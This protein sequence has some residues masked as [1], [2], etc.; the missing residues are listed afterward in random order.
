MSL[1]EVAYAIEDGFSLIMSYNVG[2][3]FICDIIKP[4]YMYERSLCS[5]ALS[6]IGHFLKQYACC[7]SGTMPRIITWF[8]LIALLCLVDQMADIL[9]RQTS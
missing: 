6:H 4:L 2:Y 5:A 9:Q 1:W 8:H 3:M 7:V